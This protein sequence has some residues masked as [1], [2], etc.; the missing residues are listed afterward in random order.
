MFSAR[1][2]GS[3][4]K[5]QRSWG[6]G[7]NGSVPFTSDWCVCGQVVDLSKTPLSFQINGENFYKPSCIM[8][9][10]FLKSQDQCLSR[11]TGLITINLPSLPLCHMKSQVNR[12]SV[13]TDK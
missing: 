2:P 9:M 6:A 5:T 13:K 3:G 7:V 12:S 4:E 1:N 8:A 11:E 10:R